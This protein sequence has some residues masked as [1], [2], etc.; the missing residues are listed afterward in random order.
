M[1]AERPVV[2]SVALN[3]LLCEDSIIAQ[4]PYM[5]YFCKVTTMHSHAAH[6]SKFT[7]N[8]RTAT[9]SPNCV[10]LLIQYREQKQSPPNNLYWVGTRFEVS[11]YSPWHQVPPPPGDQFGDT[12]NQWR[13]SCVNTLP[14]TV[15]VH[16]SCLMTWSKVPPAIDIPQ[17]L[18]AASSEGQSST[19]YATS[20]I[21]SP[22]IL[23]EHRDFRSHSDMLSGLPTCLRNV[24]KCCR[25]VTKTDNKNTAVPASEH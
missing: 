17:H 11:D 5:Q 20:S 2:M 6:H 21:R 16:L 1:T 13:K 19:N 22:L 4:T 18:F 14:I 25:S 15:K 12:E 3:G 9:A 23:S 10:N 24:D 8:S 7:V